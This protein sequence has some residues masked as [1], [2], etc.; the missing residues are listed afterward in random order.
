M[1]LYHGIDNFSADNIINAGI[2]LKCGD[3]SVDNAQ[4]FYMT[5]NFEFALKRAEMMTKR[6]SQF[7]KKESLAPVVLEIE[8]D[9]PENTD[10]VSIKNFDKT[11]F[12]WIEFVVLNRLGNRFLREHNILSANHNLDFKYDIVIDETADS[13]IGEI[14]SKIRYAGKD[15]DINPYIEKVNTAS[16]KIWGR[17]ISVH[18][19]KA[20][21]MCIKSINIK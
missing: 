17:Q 18:S 14:V 1:F 7:Y 13:E 4:G 9:L 6:C 11:D 20:I 5:P 15:I 8:L 21:D 2:D 12:E 19:K 16:N 3:E 10:T